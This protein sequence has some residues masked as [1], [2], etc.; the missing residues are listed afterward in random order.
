MK[1]M[2]KIILVTALLGL[3]LSCNKDNDKSDTL[4]ASPQN[5]RG[6]WYIDKVIKADGSIEPYTHLCP[7][8]RDRVEYYNFGVRNYIFYDN[9]D[10]QYDDLSC[11]P[12]QLIDSRMSQCNYKFNGTY[13][14]TA[15]TLRIDY[16][17]VTNFLPP[18]NNLDNI[19]G[20]ILSR[21]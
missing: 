7:T 17:E 2:K 21:N 20:I 1:R 19:K 13:T 3:V 8:N 18:A 10:P 16:D 11:S 4:D 14:L 5:L 15:T 9:C 12:Y 6:F